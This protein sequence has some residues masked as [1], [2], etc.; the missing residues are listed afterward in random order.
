[1]NK[2]RILL[3]TA[4]LLVATRATAADD[5]GATRIALEGR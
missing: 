2:G 1:M 4:L 3:L 5:P